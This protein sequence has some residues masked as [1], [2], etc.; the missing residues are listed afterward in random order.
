MFSLLRRGPF[1]Q[2][3]RSLL[4]P[5]QT[6]LVSNSNAVYP[7]KIFPTAPLTFLEALYIRFICG[8]GSR[9]EHHRYVEN[10]GSLFLTLSY[11]SLQFRAVP[12][13]PFSFPVEFSLYLQDSQIIILLKQLCLSPC[14][15]QLSVCQDWL[16]VRLP[17]PVFAVPNPAAKTKTV[18]Q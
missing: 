17:N 12:V 13:C 14:H 6:A 7:Q 15:T 8:S 18:T 4:R 5:F 10:T 3:T 11:N 9:S 1:I 2:Y 16:K